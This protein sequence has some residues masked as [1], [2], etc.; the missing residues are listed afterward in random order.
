MG[1]R[2]LLLPLVGAVFVLYYLCRSSRPY[3]RALIMLVLIAVFASA[4]LSCARTTRDDRAASN[5]GCPVASGEPARIAGQGY[6]LRWCQEFDGPLDPAVWRRGLW[7]DSFTPTSQEVFVSNGTLKLVSKRANGYRTAAI[8]TDPSQAQTSAWREGYFE[9]RVRMTGGRG[10][11]PAFFLLSRTHRWNRIWPR[12]ACPD[13]ACLHAEVDIFEGQGVEPTVFYG[14][15]HRNSCS[16]YGPNRLNSN[17]RIDVGR[18]LYGDWHK[19]ALKWTATTVSWYLDDQLVSSA[20][21]FDSTAQGMFMLLSSQVGGWAAGN[22]PDS[23]TPDDLVMEYDWV[24]VWQ[25]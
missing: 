7:Y 21:T 2:T 24:R 25:R 6:S 16:C 8:S 1:A 3:P 4:F 15:I 20:P 23:T 22:T 5:N 12:P 11:W 9:G 13:P 18:N 14:T 10:N 17:N 19:F